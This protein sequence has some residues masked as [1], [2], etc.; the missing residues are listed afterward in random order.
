MRF[1]SSFRSGL[2]AQ[3]VGQLFGEE[4]V[5]FKEKINFKLAG[6]AGFKAHQARMGSRLCP[7]P[8]QDAPAWTTFNQ[9]RHITAMVAADKADESNGCM[10]M[11][12]GLLHGLCKLQLSISQDSTRWERSHTRTGIWRSRSASS[13]SG[14]P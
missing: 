2:M 10:F 4:S 9:S 7:Y 5:L 14:I 1:S 13:G 11:V 12:K 6:A 3:A 8:L